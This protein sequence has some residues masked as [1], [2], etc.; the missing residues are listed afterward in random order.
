MKDL[1]VRM[2]HHKNYNDSLSKCIKKTIRKLNSLI[3]SDL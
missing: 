2:R 3:I 1:D